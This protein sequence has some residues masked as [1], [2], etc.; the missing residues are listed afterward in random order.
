LVLCNLK[1]PGGLE[2][3]SIYAWSVREIILGKI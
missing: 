3:I 2:K 1:F